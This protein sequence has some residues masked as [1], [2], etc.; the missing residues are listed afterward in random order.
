LSFLDLVHHAP[1]LL[2]LTQ[3]APVLAEIGGAL[4][5]SGSAQVDQ[6]LEDVAWRAQV[7]G[8]LALVLG[9]R[10]DSAH[11][12]L[13]RA[14]DG[15]SWVVPQLCAAAFLVDREFEAAAEERLLGTLRRAPKAIG[16]LV[17]AYHRLLRP[18]MAIV[19]QLRRH[20]RIL[21]GEE[22]RIGVRGVDAWLDGLPQ[23]CDAATQQRWWRLPS[24][25]TPSFS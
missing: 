22:A 21:G 7:I 1:Q 24:P 2:T 23:C 18:K 12:A 20:D 17:R 16:A 8:A 9:E 13:W 3:A 5:E 19:A 4:A 6:M 14:I 10:R 11:P 25:R 15:G